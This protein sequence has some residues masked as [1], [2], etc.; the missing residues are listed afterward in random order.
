MLNSC[1]TQNHYDH[2]TSSHCC[3][4]PL[5]GGKEAQESLM[6]LLEWAG[7]CPPDDLAVQV[8]NH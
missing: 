2:G 5:R 4:T 3:R 7:R 8:T 6:Q 1:V